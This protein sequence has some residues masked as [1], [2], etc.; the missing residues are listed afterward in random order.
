M[1]S[2]KY[3]LRD[4]PKEDRP[5]ERLKTVGTDNL[6]IQELLAL[7]IEKG[8]KGKSVLQIAQE[9]LSHFGNLTNIKEAS[10]E[11]L[12]KVSG[13]GFATACKLKASFALGE[14]AKI[15]NNK[16]H[17]KIDKPEDVFNLLKNKIGN[18]KRE[19]LVA[20]SLNASNKIIDINNVAIGTVNDTLSHPREIFR[21][22]IKNSAVS[23][24]IVHNHP[25]GNLKPSKADLQFSQQIIQAGKL[26][27]IKVID[28][29]I[30]TKDGFRQIQDF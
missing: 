2:G 6:S 13:I 18:K 24:I 8:K 11:E 10:I 25:S 16:P 7:I 9:L 4:L 27:G 23:V 21:S 17:P 5:R 19:Y 30:I 22:A 15:Q 28:N 20:L 3:T 12:K 29:L 1:M 14:R 26:I